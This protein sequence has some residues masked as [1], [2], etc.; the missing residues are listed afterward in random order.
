MFDLKKWLAASVLA[1]TLASGGAWGQVPIKNITVP[2]PTNG[3]PTILLHVNPSTTPPG[4]QKPVE[5]PF[6]LFGLFPPTVDGVC[7]QVTNS[8]MAVMDSHG[9]F[10]VFTYKTGYVPPATI[11]AGRKI[12]VSYKVLDNGLFQLTS[13][14]ATGDD[15]FTITGAPI[16]TEQTVGT[17]APVPTGAGVP[18]VNLKPANGGPQ[19]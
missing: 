10:K 8:Y 7:A 9:Q 6:D 11:V 17:A 5:K 15:K 13:V 18:N 14:R 3:G 12:H 19:N 4:Y 16:P 2:V 1:A